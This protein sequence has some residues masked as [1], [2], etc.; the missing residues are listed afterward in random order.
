MYR[1][2]EQQITRMHVSGPIAQERLPA[3]TFGAERRIRVE[4]T[5]CVVNDI[6]AVAAM[7]QK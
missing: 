7:C 4:D 5:G 3:A 1:V 2:D 6:V